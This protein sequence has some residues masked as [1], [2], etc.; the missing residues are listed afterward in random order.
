MSS[1][2]HERSFAR[3]MAVQVLY[4]ANITD[5]PAD[6]IALKEH[7]VPDGGSL[8]EYAITLLNGVSAH[9]LEIDRLIAE[10]SE[11]WSLERMPLVD[12]AVLRLALYEML[13]Q[14][15]VP[16]SVAINEAV[17]LAKDFGGAEESARFVNGIL[18]TVARNQTSDQP[19]SSCESSSAEA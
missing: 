8:P 12:R 11:N 9:M 13:Y 3:R 19:K 18:G 2:R 1:K 16:V 5:T 7:P 14:D 15:D 10:S 17:E 6:K 4:Q